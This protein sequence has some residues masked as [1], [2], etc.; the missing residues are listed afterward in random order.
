MKSLRHPLFLGTIACLLVCSFGSEVAAGQSKASCTF[1][2]FTLPNSIASGNFALG[3]NSYSTVV[4]ELEDKN[5]KTGEG[6][7]RYSGGRVNF[8]APN[9]QTALTARNDVG[10]SVG[11]EYT[12]PSTQG[13]MLHGSSGVT[14]IVHPKAVMGTFPQGINRWNTVVGYYLDANDQAHGFK[15]VASGTFVD[16]D[17]PNAQGTTPMG[18]NDNGVIVGGYNDLNGV[19]GF[20]Y[21][22]GKWAS[23]E[24]P[25][26]RIGT[27]ILSGVSNANTMIGFNNATQQGTSFLY[28]NGVFKVI[29]DSQAAGGTYANGIAA[30]GLITGDLYSTSNRSSQQGFIAK[31]Q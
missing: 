10:N 8:F 3:I 15:R 16:I 18:I 31:C 20:I 6:F 13:F 22:G 17:F 23:V 7:I 27:T 9:V 14:Q 29:S 24:Y 26:V 11:Q 12:T 28:K 2:L 19:H 1:T 21:A 25:K 5:T 4:G 30:N